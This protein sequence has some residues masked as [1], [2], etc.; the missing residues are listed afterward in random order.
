M[1][2]NELMGTPTAAPDATVASGR[3]MTLSELT[4]APAPERTFLGDLKGFLGEK[5]ADVGGFVKS[6]GEFAGAGIGMAAGAVAGVARTGEEMAKGTSRREALQEG[7]A[8][9][10][11]VGAALNPVTVATKLLGYEPD[12]SVIDSVMQKL[13]KAIHHYGEK[14]EVGTNRMLLAEDIDAFAGLLMGAGMGKATLKGMKAGVEKATAPRTPG[15]SMVDMI[16]TEEPPAQVGLPEPEVMT[17]EALKAAFKA[18]KE[19]KVPGVSDTAAVESI[20]AKAKAR[21]LAEVG[22]KSPEQAVAESKTRIAEGLTLEEARA[23]VDAE[24]APPTPPTDFELGRAKIQ[25]G[26][27]FL[28]T[29]EE[30]I[31]LRRTAE[32]GGR[33]VDAEG[34]RIG[35][36]FTEHGEVDPRLL[37]ALGIT[38]AAVWAALN[39]EDVDKLATVGVLGATALTGHTRASPLGALLKE[40]AP[41]TFRTLE[42]LPKGATDISRQQITD[43]LKKPELQA[44]RPVFERVLGALPEG[45]VNAH[46]LMSGLLEETAGWKLA[47]KETSKYA[48]Y[49]LENISAPSTTDGVNFDGGRGYRDGTPTTTLYQLPEHMQMSDANHFN[50]SRLF[51]WARS[52]IEDGVKHVVEIQSDLAQHAKEIPEAKRAELLQTGEVLQRQM[53]AYRDYYA[54]DRTSVENAR[55]AV[56]RIDAINPDATMILADQLD[57]QLA[58]GSL[59]AKSEFSTDLAYVN[60]ILDEAKIPSKAREVFRRELNARFHSLD[61]LIAENKTALG[62]AAVSS[63]LSPI[64]KN[65][66]RRLIREELLKNSQGDAQAA[67]LVEDQARQVAQYRQMQA[68][69]G[70]G[71][72]GKTAE[73]MGSVLAQAEARLKQLQEQAAPKDVV[74]FATAD[75]VAKVEGWPR[76]I[77]LPLAQRAASLESAKRILAEKEASGEVAPKQVAHVAHLQR[78]YDNAK[79]GNPP[80]FLDPGHQSI[81]NRYAGEITRYLKGLG[82]KEVIDAQGHTWIEVPTRAAVKNGTIHMMGSADPKLLAGIAAG[83]AAG[84]YLLTSPDRG[85]LAM[86]GLGLGL[87]LKGKS[88]PML[89][90][91]IRAGGKDAQHAATELYRQNAPRTLRMLESKF[92]RQGVDVESVLQEGMLSAMKAVA[93]GTFRGESAFSTFLHKAVMNKAIDS[94][95]RAEVRPDTVSMSEDPATG[96]SSIADTLGHQE[97]PE[98]A[99]L[100]KALGGRLEAA[101]EKLD[102]RF[103]EAFLAVEAEGMSYEEA[104][105]HFGVPE[106]TI[107]SRVGRAKE[108]LRGYLRD[109]RDTSTGAAEVPENR[110]TPAAERG[111]ADPKVLANI[112]I[113][114]GGAALGAYLDKDAPL[115][116][117][118]WGAGVGLLLANAKPAAWVE[119][120]K[121]AQNKGEL[122]RIDELTAQTA[123]ETKVFGRAVDQMANRIIETVP[124]VARREAI[125]D[126]LEGERPV[127]LSP[128]ELKIAQEIKGFYEGLGQLAKGAGVVKQLLGDYATRIY[129]KADRGFFEGKQLGGG[130]SL[131]SPFGKP[132]GYKTRAEAEAAGYVPVTTD[133]ARVITMYSDSLGRAIANNRFIETLRE[134]ALPDGTKLVQKEGKAPSEFVFVDA[135]Q[136]RGL[137]VHPDIAADLRFVFDSSNPGAILGALDAINSTQKRLGVSLSLF[138]ATALEHAMLGATSIFKSP[139]RGV[140]VFG[141]SFMPVVFGES[142]AVKMIRE[143]GAGDLI[144]SAMKDGVEFSRQRHGSVVAEERPGIYKGLETATMF[145]D[146]TVPGLGKYSTGAILALNHIFDDAMWARFHTTLKIET[147]A[148]KVSELSRNN[149]RMVEA[150][151][152]PPKSRAEIGRAAASFTNDLYGGLNYQQIVGEFSSRWGRELASAALSP[153]GRFGM[154]LVLFAPDWT[155]STTR[156]FVKAFGPRESAVIAGGILGSQI[157]PENK[158]VGGFVGAG[159][160]LAAG[161]AGGLKGTPSGGFRGLLH[162]TE[163]ADLHRQYIMRSAFLYT[164][165]ADTLNYQMSGHHFWDNKDPTRLDRGDGTTMQLSKHFMEP[166]HWLLDPRK[167]AMGKASFLV[168]ETASQLGDVEYWSP[169]GAPR[170]GGVERGKDVSIGTRLGH[171]ARQFTPISAQGFESANPQKAAWSMAGMPV[172]GKTLEERAAAKAESKRLAVQRRID[173]RLSE[174]SQ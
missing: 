137:R 62:G 36:G 139:I 133:I 13:G 93:D 148:D 48:D 114:G 146:K 119:A 60:Y 27:G 12:P 157:D 23:K 17:P 151:K 125:Y 103:K 56:Q 19:N 33:I 53:D 68:T 165:I 147:Y 98:K 84:A 145:L 127:R 138:H 90:E 64:L 160:G 123:Y 150:G 142:L 41:Y 35:S 149:A 71:R 173:K 94:L 15:T 109:Y 50:D 8:T 49:G 159:L 117:A 76:E 45:K 172:Y 124:D 135:P 47:P 164:A 163:L 152:E 20:F 128:I 102:P 30:K 101:M 55:K 141:Q 92:G 18:A 26:Q 37:T 72:I 31:A 170:M 39:P 131:E 58:E 70:Y 113:L 86:A 6:V 112:A 161:M 69:G 104:G 78:L 132:R 156:A 66:P 122:V 51:G 80:A 29:P 153:T 44:E 9:A 40:S 120:V 46:D 73:E 74:R 106:G 61:Q 88:E 67:M 10:G 5:A 43:L 168:K 95:R 105:T 99:V 54:G 158:G 169:K 57:L 110:A 155:I 154:R 52:F 174:Q 42:M 83:V 2:L 134:T 171:V 1:T 97:T 82:G 115:T 11:R 136:L 34:N 121:R 3:G 91:A 65:W 129:Q 32:A 75:T 89:L 130:T 4:G 63:Q 22:P 38:S 16:P 144:D 107:K 143:G 118:A 77:D 87:A 79:A 100:N 111:S 59:K 28:L 14:V 21:G 166:F 24:R 162:P 140:R 25:H 85:E 7:A 81:Y 96:R 116:G 167:Q 108:A 126:H